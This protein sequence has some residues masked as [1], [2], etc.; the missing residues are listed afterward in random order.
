MNLAQ[1]KRWEEY[2]AGKT[3]ASSDIASHQ[4]IASVASQMLGDIETAH[5]VLDLG[6]GDGHLT[7]RIAE[8]MST[9]PPAIMVAS[10][11][12][13]S[14]LSEHWRGPTSISRVVCDASKLP[15]KSESM[16]VVLSFGYASVASYFDPTIQ[17]EINRVLTPGGRLISDFRNSFSLWMV[18][19]RPHWFAKS[20]IR[21]LGFGKHHYHVGGIG[22]KRYFGQARLQLVARRYLL[23][24][25]PLNLLGWQ[26]LVRLD[27]LLDRLHLNRLLGRIFVARFDKQVDL[28]VSGEG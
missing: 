24:F 3:V 13:A 19:M 16:T 7:G 9:P 28:G 25:L 8:C 27:R 5:V 21:Y 6:A 10:D 22:L 26:T 11:L 12:S 15:F 20:V 2:W 17:A 4:R 1:T 23:G 18:A 14:A